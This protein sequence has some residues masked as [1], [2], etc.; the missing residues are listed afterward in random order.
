MP[1]KCPRKGIGIRTKSEPINIRKGQVS[2]MLYKKIFA[3][4]EVTTGTPRERATAIYNTI[5]DNPDYGYLADAPIDWLE[6][7]I[8]TGEI[9]TWR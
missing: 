3:L 7:K 6:H 1:T 9:R 4:Y 2:T 5:H 8:E